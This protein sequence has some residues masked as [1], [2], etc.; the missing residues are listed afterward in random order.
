ML[1]ILQFGFALFQNSSRLYNLTGKFS[2]M[3]SPYRKKMNGT[4]QKAREMNASRELPQP[5]PSLAYIVG[6][7][8]GRMQPKM[9]RRTVFAARAEAAYLP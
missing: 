1:V 8:R 2:R 7:A 5:R 4:G 9:E 3:R 6:P